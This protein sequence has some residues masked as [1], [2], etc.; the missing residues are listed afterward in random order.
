[1]KTKHFV[2]VAL[3]SNFYT[4][5]LAGL[6]LENWLD[7]PFTTKNELRNVDAYDVLGTTIDQIATYHET[8]GTTGKPTP[9]WFS[10][11]DI[12]QEANVVLH[13]SLQLHENDIVLNRFPFAMAIPSFIIYWAAAKA[14]AAHIGVDKA[15]MVTPDRRVV[16]IIERTNPSI[17]TMLPSEAEKLYEVGKQ[18]GVLLPNP[19]LRALVLAGELTTP[20][21][22]NYLEKLWGVPVYLLFGSTETGGLFMSCENGHY[23]LNHSNALVESVDE[24]G[25]P[26]GNGLKGNCVIST[27]REGMPLLRYYNQDVIELR[28]GS[29]CGCG[30]T[31]PIMIHYGRKEDIVHLPNKEVTFYDLQEAVYSLENIPFMWK[32]KVFQEHVQFIFQYTDKVKPSKKIIE[33]EISRKLGFDVEVLLS[34]IFPL[35]KLTEKPAYGK[36]A[37]IE[38]E[39]K[40]LELIK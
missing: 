4:E 40:E 19:N 30:Q 26:L 31:E 16:E 29:T 37:H 5:K 18:M 33:E 17:L 28:D 14:G 10:H 9:S 21:R 23:H 1:M 24:N 39:T 20:Q 25:Y 3:K 6:N 27:A 13:S 15:S 34:D 36:Y 35:Q 2:D 22:K 38:R 11:K 8:S 7:I 32:V 12:E